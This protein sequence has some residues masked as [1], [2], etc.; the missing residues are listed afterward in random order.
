MIRAP[1]GRPHKQGH[2]CDTTP[3]NGGPANVELPYG[4]VNKR[5]QRRVENTTAIR[6]ERMGVLVPM[7]KNVGIAG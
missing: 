6:D 4:V 7:A 2:E 1:G 5:R 3:G